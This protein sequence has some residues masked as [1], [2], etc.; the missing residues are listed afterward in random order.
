[1]KNTCLVL[2][3]GGLRGT[4]TGG[5]LEY[6]LEKNINF[7]RVVGVSA[8]ACMGA[9]YMSRQKGR[10]WKVNVEYP[11]DRRY[12]GFLHLLTKGAYFNTEFVF[13]E[14]PNRLVPYDENALFKN[15][16]EFDIVTTSLNT[17]KTVIFTK[18]DIAKIGV[19]RVLLASSSIPFLARPIEI[20]G[21]FYF[22]GGVT[23]SIPAEYGLSKHSKAVV[24]LTR[25]RGYRKEKLK[26]SFLLKLAFRKY[27]DFVKSILRRNEEYNLCLDFCNQMEKEGKIFII[28][29][30]PEFSAG[31]TEHSFD[32]RAGLYKHGYELIRKEF[33]N[34]QGFLE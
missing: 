21:Q 15:D 30:S 3:G 29:P 13:E 22:D 9:S 32:K 34:L 20:D 19:C 4:F 18:K 27:P 33:D 7:N 1:M 2:E 5:V 24:V 12:M 6:F 23:A 31:R 14:I 17:G 26:G 11:S 28:A 8:G 16:T 10:N 25:P